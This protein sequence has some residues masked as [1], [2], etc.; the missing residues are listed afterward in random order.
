MPTTP[1]YD[2]TMTPRTV[3]TSHPERVADMGAGVMQQPQLHHGTPFPIDTEAP[4]SYNVPPFSPSTPETPT[5]QRRR[6]TLPSIIRASSE[7]ADLTA[8]WD[9]Q[10]ARQ[11]AG[12]D[13][14]NPKLSIRDSDIGVAVTSSTAN[15][16]NPNASGANLG[17]ASNSGNS[18]AAPKRR[19]RSAGALHELI[20]SQSGMRVRKRS[21]EIRYWRQSLL[22]PAVTSLSTRSLN[23]NYGI[24]DSLIA[25]PDTV[26]LADPTYVGAAKTSDNAF[27]F[28]RS[29][30][31]EPSST[32]KGYQNPDPSF[33]SL[34]KRLDRLEAEVAAMDRSLR[35]L[36]GRSHRQTVIMQEDAGPGRRRGRQSRWL[37]RGEHEELP[38]EERP[39]SSDS[40][41]TPPRLRSPFLPSMSGGGR[42]RRQHHSHSPSY[43]ISSNSQHHPYNS[44]YTYGLSAE[45]SGNIQQNADA[46]T[47]SLTAAAAAAAHEQVRALYLLLSQERSKRKALEV[48]VSA[49]QRNVSDVRDIAAAAMASAAKPHLYEMPAAPFPTN[50]P[51][52]ALPPQVLTDE[53]A[54]LMEAD[55]RRQTQ[56]SRFSHFDSDDDIDGSGRMGQAGG[57]TSAGELDESEGASNTNRSSN[58]NIETKERKRQS[59]RK[60]G[61]SIRHDSYNVNDDEDEKVGKSG[62]DEEDTAP[63]DKASTERASIS[64][65]P[66]L[67]AEGLQ[68]RRNRPDILNVDRVSAGPRRGCPVV[69]A[70]AAGTALITS[71]PRESPEAD[72][73]GIGGT[74]GTG[75][76]GREEVEGMESGDLRSPSINSPYTE[77]DFQTP[78]EE[79]APFSSTLGNEG[80][81]QGMSTRVPV[82]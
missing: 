68:Q 24:D 76:P 45:A 37:Q 71:Q 63:T 40:S 36:K 32:E 20:R 81:G 51:L 34:K 5:Q 33:T 75:G 80:A 57:V 72:A 67:P 62:R 21:D 10:Y 44:V 22:P 77:D 82:S 8:L 61:L 53:T 9:R 64:S 26:P 39:S 38:G 78:D 31:V 70:V 30:E 54:A 3:P 49:L 55:P 14:Q 18:G 1:G 65:V 28:R 73:G 46:A 60:S 59:S 19:S 25:S 17:L 15:N 79:H 56:V 6:A 23:Y 43:R 13:D 29:T 69:A 42:W 2:G 66:K 47:N 50:L 35:S 12:G 7:A 41:G 27:N 52:S 48:H 74:S 4:T 16:I 58:T 11:I